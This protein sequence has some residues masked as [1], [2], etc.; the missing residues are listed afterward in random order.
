[1]LVRNYID[2]INLIPIQKCSSGFLCPFC[3]SVELSRQCS[4]IFLISAV[5]TCEPGSLCPFH[6]FCPLL[7]RTTLEKIPSISPFSI[8]NSLLKTS[9]SLGRSSQGILS[10]YPF[11]AIIIPQRLGMYYAEQKKFWKSCHSSTLKKK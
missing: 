9:A 1:M 7:L 2:R 3:S 8:S 11:I 4:D 6:F 10:K 5:S